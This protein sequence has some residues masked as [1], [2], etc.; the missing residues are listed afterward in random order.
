MHRI[1]R[2]LVCV[3]ALALCATACDL[4]DSSQRRVEKGT[5]AP[6]ERDAPSDATPSTLDWQ[7]CGSVDCARLRVALAPGTPSLGTIS[8]ELVRHR[9]T[10]DRIG[11]LLTNPGGPGA[12]SLWIA[13]QATDIFPAT[14]LEHFDVIAWDPRGVGRSTAVRCG[15]KLDTF[16]SQDRSPD[17]AKE[18]ASNVAAA[19]RLAGEC[20]AKSGRILPYL[21]SRNTVADMD[22]IRRALGD[23][24]ISYLGFSYGTYLGALYADTYPE[25]VRAMVLDGAIDPSLSSEAATAEQADGF[26]RALDAFLSDCARRS[27]CAFKGG[28]NPQRAYDELMRSIDAEPLFAR[29]DGEQRELGPGEA[30]IGV[31]EALYGGRESWPEL[32]AAL[33]DAAR[34]NGAKL[35]EL[36]DQYTDRDKGGTYSNQTAAFYAIGCLDAPAPATVREVERDAKSAAARAPHFGVTTTWLGLPCTYWPVK[37]TVTPAPLHA[38]G[39][40]PILVLGTTHDPATPFAWAR[41]LAAQLDS[42]HLVALDDEGHAAYGRGNECID[43]IVHAY[44]LDLKVPRDGTQC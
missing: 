8:L 11:A 22:A 16:W 41:A 23:D 14:L 27:D 39:A 44:L 6:G 30:D 3:V 25:H 42:G 4:P 9:A 34:S 35:L 33:A 15:E 32:A 7:P 13:Q 10:G 20:E 24:K 19:K 37:S 43:D 28:G 31:A 21:S 5:T 40:P 1:A 38:A 12:S 26:D 18:V 17:N 36:S 2:V 29:V